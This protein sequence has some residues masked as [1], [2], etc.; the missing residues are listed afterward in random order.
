MIQ[1]I[2]PN[3]DP[4]A[5]VTGA[6]LTTSQIPIYQGVLP[7]VTAAPTP[8]IP[9]PNITT[10]L[11][12]NYTTVLPSMAATG[13]YPALGSYYW[14]CLRRPANLFAPVSANNPMVVVDATRFPYIDGTAKLGSGRPPPLTAPPEPLS[15]C[16]RSPQIPWVP[17][18]PCRPRSLLSGINPI[19]AVMPCPWRAANLLGTPAAAGSTTPVDTRYGYTEQIVAPSVDSQNFM[20]T[21]GIYATIGGNSYYATQ[22]IYHTLGGANELEQGSGSSV[23]EPWDYLPF[24]DRDFTSV[25][26]L[27]LV[28]GCSP[29][30]FTKQ[31]VEFA[32]AIGTVA[33]IFNAVVPN[34]GPPQY[35]A[36][37]GATTGPLSRDRSPPP[38]PSTSPPIRPVP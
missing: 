17:R 4:V 22:Y 24:N 29:G 7:G 36:N 34:E 15:R 13:P 5:P 16:P 6:G 10:S 3:M 38:S 11:P 35:V 20:K 2:K 1:T 31:F 9:N 28:P 14:V 23:A 18:P 37:P 19:A 25:A 30:L 26:E 32:P 12:P 21:Q 8:T 27:M 33:N